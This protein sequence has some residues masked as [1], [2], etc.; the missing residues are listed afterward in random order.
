[1]TLTAIAAGLDPAFPRPR[2]GRRWSPMQVKRTLQA[3]N[4]AQG[5]T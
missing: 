1:M 3:L 5:P 2:E 4:E